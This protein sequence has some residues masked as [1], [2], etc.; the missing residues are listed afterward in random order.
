MGH[1]IIGLYSIGSIS[2]K[3][4]IKIKGHNNKKKSHPIYTVKNSL[5]SNT[6]G[7]S[8]MTNTRHSFA[9]KEVYYPFKATAFSKDNII[10]GIEYIDDNHFVLSIQFHP[11]D[12]NN[13]ENLY[14]I[15]LKETIKRKKA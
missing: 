2:D 15:F 7:D 13:T 4:L 1:Q 6:L 12:L 10:E 3:D 11:E 5:L 8:I 14:N 9:I